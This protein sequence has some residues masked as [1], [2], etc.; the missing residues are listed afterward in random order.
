MEVGFELNNILQKEGYTHLKFIE[1]KGVCGLMRFMFTVGL[2]YGLT[3]HLYEGR[4]CYESFLD[5]KEALDNWD[6]VGDP[7]DTEWIKHKG[8]REYSN[9]LKD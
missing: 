8:H 3:A 6:G 2:V 4:Y 9:P 1:G 7:Q 5:A